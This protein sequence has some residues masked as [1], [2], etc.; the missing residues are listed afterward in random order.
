MQSPLIFSACKTSREKNTLVVQ[1]RGPDYFRGW[2]E[3]SDLESFIS[4]QS[5][6]YGVDLD[7]TNYVNKRRI[8]LNPAPPKTPGNVL[9]GNG[10]NGHKNPAAATSDGADGGGKVHAAGGTAAAAASGGALVTSRFVWEKFRQGCSLRMPCP[11]K[12]SDPLHRLLSAL[13]EEFG[14]MVGSNVYLTPPRSQGFAPH[15]DDIEAFLLQVGRDVFKLYFFKE[16]KNPFH[17]AELVSL[18]GEKRKG[19]MLPSRSG[20]LMRQCNLNSETFPLYPAARRIYTSGKEKAFA[21]LL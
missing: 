11:Q 9:G 2:L 21:F 18:A 5:M 8:T 14:C 20:T 13:E 16:K 6:Q 17:F 4:T 7:V 1:G 15:W 12:F 3:T 10:G 19:G